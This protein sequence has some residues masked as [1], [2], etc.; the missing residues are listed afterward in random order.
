MMKKV[1]IYIMSSLLLMGC[2]ETIDIELNDEDNQ[3]L[4]VEGWVTD[5]PGKQEVRL[6]KTTSY[7]YNQSAP[8]ASGAMVQVSDG[9]QTWDFQEV[10]PG[11]YRPV[12]DFVGEPE[13]TYT[14]NID[15]EGV[16]YTASSYMRAGSPIDSMAFEY[17]D[18][19][20][21]FGIDET[22]WYNILIW[23]QEPEGLGDHYMWRTFVN[24]E[25]LRD[26]L[27]EISFVDDGIYDGNY[28]AGVDVDYLD[29]PSE[30]VPGD[31]IL[32]EQWNIGLEAYE[33]FIGIMNET[34]WNGGLFDAPPANVETNISNGALGYFGAASVTSKSAV[35]P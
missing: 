20:E 12:P 10:E 9:D 25:A 2:T 15:F 31:T 6:T 17:I 7:F 5:Y 19:L 24:G 28:V 23:T 1:W 26:T 18:P 34:A 27:S 8:V 21:E 33:I 11:L 35:I 16:E 29:T 22:P 30:A 14:L 32:L 13:K 3:R 4:V